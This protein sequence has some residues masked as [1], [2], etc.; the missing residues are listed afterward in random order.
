MALKTIRQTF[1]VDVVFTVRDQTA[2]NSHIDEPAHKQAEGVSNAVDKLLGNACSDNP[3]SISTTLLG[4]VTSCI[5]KGEVP[6]NYPDCVEARVVRVS[7]QETTPRCP[8]PPE[9]V[10]MHPSAI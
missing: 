2:L 4:E 10:P 6:L 8:P 3:D 1:V 9:A 5:I 7:Y